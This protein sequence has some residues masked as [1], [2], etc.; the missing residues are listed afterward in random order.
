MTG[1]AAPRS[2]RPGSR[3]LLRAGLVLTAAGAAL[4]AGSASAAAVAT[5]L[6]DVDGA[7]AVSALTAAAHS[8][9]APAK[10]LQLDPLANTSVDPLNNAL[11]TQVAD[12]KP[13]TTA[14]A[15]GPLARG[16][17]LDDLPL[18]GPVTKLLPG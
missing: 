6:G 3:A 4:G 7:A 11:G 15:T 17:S 9:L 18:V 10:N 2:P 13:V 14:V 5:P 16:G 8:A 1:H 12:F